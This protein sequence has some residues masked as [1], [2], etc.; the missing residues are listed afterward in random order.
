MTIEER[1]IRNNRIATINT[2]IVLI[3]MA[4]FIVGLVFSFMVGFPNFVVHYPHKSIA[5][6]LISSIGFGFIEF[7]YNVRKEERERR[8]KK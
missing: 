5:W 8:K 4:V 1:K 3:C 2:I 7:Y 6:I